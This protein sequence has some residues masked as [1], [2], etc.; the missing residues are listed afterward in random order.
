MT[1]APPPALARIPS[2]A[3]KTSCGNAAVSSDAAAAT[4]RGAVEPNV[5][6]GEA[7]VEVKESLYAWITGEGGGRGR[8]FG[9]YF[10][11]ARYFITYNN[12]FIHH[13]LDPLEQTPAIA[14]K[15]PRK[16]TS[17]WIATGSAISDTGK[18]AI[19]RI[20]DAPAPNTADSSATSAESKRSM[21][22]APG[23]A[24]A[25]MRPHAAIRP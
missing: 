21:L 20:L 8:L 19:K 9:K 1:D 15:P 16:K 3:R 18:L 24:T 6:F 4:E 7:K 17:A 23:K 11:R 10:A 2:A 12:R 13:A 22:E 25:T 5:P 14:S